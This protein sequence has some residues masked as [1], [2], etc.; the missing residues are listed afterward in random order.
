[1]LVL[2][3]DAHARKTQ[4]LQEIL[5]SSSM[6]AFIQDDGAGKLHRRLFPRLAL[7]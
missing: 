5:A 3:A 2:W 4:N 1:M 6:R 7:D